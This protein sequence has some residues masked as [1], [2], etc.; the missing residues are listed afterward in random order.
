LTKAEAL[1]AEALIAEALIAEALYPEQELRSCPSLAHYS[2]L[3][4]S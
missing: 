1:I 4:V 2:S 3:N